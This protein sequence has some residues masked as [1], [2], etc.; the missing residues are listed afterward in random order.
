M[1]DLALM[2]MIIQTFPNAKKF[3]GIAILHPITNNAIGIV[4][5]L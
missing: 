4:C 3:Y 5:I 2:V 1:T